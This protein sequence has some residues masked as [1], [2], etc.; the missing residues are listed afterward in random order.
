[1]D[2]RFT[3]ARGDIVQH[4]IDNPFD[5]PEDWGRVPRSGVEMRS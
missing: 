4:R 2:S 5:V 1:M 3:T